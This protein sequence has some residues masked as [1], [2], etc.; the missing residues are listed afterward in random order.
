MEL[1]MNCFA[2]ALKCLTVYTAVI[3]LFF[4]LPRRRT[5][6]APP[7][8][9][10]AVL[11]AARNEEAVIGNL[12]KSLHDQDYPKALFD[13][14]VM[15]NNCTD[16]TEAA[17][18]RAGAKILPCLASVHC[19]GDVLHQAMEQLMGKYDAYCVF[20]ADNIAAPGFL[21]RMNDAV[22]SG[23]Q[24]AQARR[25]ASNPYSSWVSGCYDLYFENFNTLYSRPRAW[26]GL[27]AKLTGTGFLFTDK[28]IQS[29]GGWNTVTLTEDTEFAAQCALA[30]APIRYVPEALCYDEQPL[31]FQTSLRQ[32]RRWSAGVQSVANRYL[33]TLLS[34]R[35][36]WLGIDFSVFLS[37]IYAQ[38]LAILPACYRLSDMS[39]TGIAMT[40][41]ISFISFWLSL[42]ATALFLCVLGRRN[43]RKMWKTI[44]LYP[45]FTASWYPLHILSLVAK[46]KTWK[47]IV[48]TGSHQRAA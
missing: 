1:V 33:P 18:R 47:P 44:L 13:I 34:Q 32:R 48:H 29:L 38:L 8:T 26:L 10:F 28:L 36:T 20:D 12:I 23:A 7:K 2:F 5:P 27:G 35:P 43:P 24:A 21:S 6:K 9:R 3:S 4:L 17:A 40:L 41:G 45:L 22:V 39:L 14:Y 15:P 25:V 16:N 37:M 11:I 31:T 30:G 19:K 42:T 46:P